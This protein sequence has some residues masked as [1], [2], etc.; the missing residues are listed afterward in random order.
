MHTPIKHVCQG[1]TLKAN[2]PFFV[3]RMKTETQV[4]K[5]RTMR[6]NKTVGMGLNGVKGRVAT[7]SDENNGYVSKGSLGLKNEVKIGD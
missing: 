4:N 1:K 2:H 5:A 7:N 3:S 6:M